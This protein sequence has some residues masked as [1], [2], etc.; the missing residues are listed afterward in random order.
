MWKETAEEGDI[1]GREFEPWRAVLT[2][3]R[4]FETLGVEGLEGRIRK[5]MDAYQEEKGDLVG[6]EDRLVVVVKALLQLA[7][8]T[9]ADTKNTK[10]TKNT[11]FPDPDVE[12][13]QNREIEFTAKNLGETIKVMIAENSEE[14]QDEEAA[15]VTP[16]R[17]GRLLSRLRLPQQPQGKQRT[18]TRAVT[19]ETLL[20]LGKS[21]GVQLSQHS[22]PHLAKLSVLSVLS[23][24][25]SAKL[26]VGDAVLLLSHDGVQQNTTPYIITAIEPGPDGKSYARF[27]DL[28]CAWPLEC[29]ERSPRSDEGEEME[30]TV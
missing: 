29:C 14:G 24:L 30:W 3:A 16:S 2:V 5:V 10:N 15:W 12:N 9:L 28:A 26:T 21:Y 4:L 17:I 1:I 27:A 25:V 20:A 23:V 18:R 19:I 11:M 6:Q 13:L 7:E 8:A 22:H